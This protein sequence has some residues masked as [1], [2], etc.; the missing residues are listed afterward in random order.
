MEKPFLF[1]LYCQWCFGWIEGFKVDNH[2]TNLKTKFLFKDYCIT[3]LKILF[4][5]AL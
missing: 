4:S 1:I 2:F 5:A 3:I